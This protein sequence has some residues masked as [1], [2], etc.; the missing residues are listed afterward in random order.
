MKAGTEHT[1]EPTQGEPLDVRFLTT[2]EGY[3]IVLLG[4]PLAE[5]L[6]RLRFEGEQVEVML[7][8]VE[9]AAF[10]SALQPLQAYLQHARLDHPHQQRIWWGNRIRG[11]W[12]TDKRNWASGRERHLTRALSQGTN[13]YGRPFKMCVFNRL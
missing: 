6:L 13:C 12:P 11:G 7:T 1:D 8:L 10:S 2:A 5:P 4:P 3:E 9:I